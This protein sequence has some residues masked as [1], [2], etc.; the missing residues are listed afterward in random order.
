MCLSYGCQ[1]MASDG[2]GLAN[3]TAEVMVPNGLN[4]ASDDSLAR[5]IGAMAVAAGE[6]PVVQHPGLWLLEYIRK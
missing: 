6:A 1:D 4:V 3:T 2:S 5:A